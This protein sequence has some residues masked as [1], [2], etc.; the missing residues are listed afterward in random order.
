[1]SLNGYSEETHG[2]NTLNKNG[3]LPNANY[4]KA[5][6]VPIGAIIPWTKTFYKITNGT[7][8]GTSSNKLINSGDTFVTDGVKKSMIVLNT[9]DGTETYVTDV[10]GET[11]LSLNDDIFVS[12]ENYEVYATPYL[13]DGFVECNGQLITDPDSPYYNQNAPDLNVTQRF[14]R[15]SSTSGATGGEDTHTL[16][17]NEMPSHSHPHT[18]SYQKPSYYGTFEEGTGANLSLISIDSESTGAATSHAAGGGQAHENR[19]AFYEVVMIW[20]IK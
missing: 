12:G 11:Q 10:D 2:Y 3:E 8:D 19:P 1:M 5:V 20:R 14:L 6:Q 13:P 15:G 4:V 18:H 7:A 16:T 9:T 17:I